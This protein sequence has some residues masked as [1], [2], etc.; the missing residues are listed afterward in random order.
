M[1]IDLKN[2]CDLNNEKEGIIRN[3]DDLQQAEAEIGQAQH[4]LELKLSF[5]LRYVAL[6]SFHI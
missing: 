2:K 3:E 1:K 6:N 4:K 5:I